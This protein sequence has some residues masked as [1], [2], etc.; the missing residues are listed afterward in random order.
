MY[1]PS[2]YIYLFVHLSIHPSFYI[3]LFIYL[4]IHSS[5]HPPIHSSIHSS[6]YS[7]HLSIHPSF[8]SSHPSIYPIYTSTPIPS[9]QSFVRSQPHYN[10]PVILGYVKYKVFLDSFHVVGEEEAKKLGKY[11]SCVCKVY[12]FGD[13]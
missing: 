1:I 11:A 8:Y 6:V 4:S 9:M 10:L 3:Y 13:N 12:W 2:I 7:S 5:I